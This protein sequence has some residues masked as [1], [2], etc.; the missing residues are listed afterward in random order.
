MRLGEDEG[1]MHTRGGNPGAP[2][3]GGRGVSVPVNRI[4]TDLSYA[5]S[6]RKPG[7]TCALKADQRRSFFAPASGA[8]PDVST[9]G[10]TDLVSIEQRERPFARIEGSSRF[11]STTTASPPLEWNLPGTLVWGQPTKHFQMALKRTLDVAVAGV[12]LILG[13]IPLALV[14][15]A[16]RID[17]PGPILYPHERIGHNGR[18][19]RMYKFRSMVA[20]A[21][22]VKRGLLA[23]NQTDTPLFKMSDDPR[24]T[25]VGRFIRRFSI[26]E[27]PQLFNVLSGQMSLVGP[28]PALPE[29]AAQY[30]HEDAHR[31]VAVPGL[32]G[33]WQV[34]GRSLLTFSEMVDLDVEYARTW[35]IWLDLKILLRTLPVVVSGRGAY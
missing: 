19:F 29:E 27:L 9:W 4:E 14:A 16:I 26:D 1:S 35:S 11:G 20:D 21:D 6:L 22:A 31:V 7:T 10:E 23:L 28:R 15:L 3:L 13:A 18:R 33:L 25:R 24:R 17:S 5:V 34:S 8:C 32:T 12:L 2:T 30:N